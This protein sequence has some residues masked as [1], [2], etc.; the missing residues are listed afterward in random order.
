MS[1]ATVEA[2]KVPQG[3]KVEW[4]RPDGSTVPGYSF[5]DGTYE[6]YRH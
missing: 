2:A 1:A 6:L 4:T 5:G 3:T